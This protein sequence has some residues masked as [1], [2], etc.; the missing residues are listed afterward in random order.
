ME[1][2]KSTFG[3]ITEKVKTYVAEHRAE[4]DREESIIEE[5]KKQDIR[6]YNRNSSMDLK[7]KAREHLRQKEDNLMNDKNNNLAKRLK[8]VNEHYKDV[9]KPKETQNPLQE[10]SDRMA[11]NKF[12]RDMRLQKASEVKRIVAEDKIRKRQEMINKQL[13]IKERNELMKLCKSA[14]NNL[15]KMRTQLR[16]S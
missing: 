5:Q 7:Q 16:K 15:Q 8:A 1:N 6:D 9:L 10:M 14:K 12:K 2:K 13:E 11:I 3:S 4:K